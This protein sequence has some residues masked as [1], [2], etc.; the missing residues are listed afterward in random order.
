MKVFITK[1]LHHIRKV[2]LKIRQKPL[3]VQFYI[4][5]I[6]NMKK[7]KTIQEIISDGGLSTNDKNSDENDNVEE[8]AKNF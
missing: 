8:D 5:N 3:K 1:V 2:K 6:I 7:Y 4:L